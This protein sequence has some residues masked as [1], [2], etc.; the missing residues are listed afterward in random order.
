[1]KNLFERYKVT[2]VYF[3]PLL[4]L[5]SF[6]FWKSIS[7]PLHDFANSY[8]PAHIVA[9]SN[10]PETSLFDIYKFNSY[11]WDLG[12]NEVLADFYLNSPFNTVAFYPFTFLEDAYLAKSIFN[13]LSS[14]CSIGFIIERK[15]IIF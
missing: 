2:L 11:I 4:L 12:Y 7:F 9:N 13:V 1:M 3:L 14:I 10:M 15:I 6:L 5:L 8:F